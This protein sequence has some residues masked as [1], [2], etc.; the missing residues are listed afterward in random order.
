MSNDE[1][2]DM[3]H[4]LCIAAQLVQEDLA[5]MLPISNED[6]ILGAA[7]ICFADQWRVIEKIGKDLIGW[8][9]TILV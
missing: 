3:E 7:A 1:T 8:D 4:P 2:D 9:M 6:Y 5:I